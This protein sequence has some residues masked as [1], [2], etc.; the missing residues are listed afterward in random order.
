[1]WSLSSYGCIIIVRKINISRSGIGYSCGV[2]GLRVTRTAKRTKRITLS[3]PG[4]GLS[5]VCE[6]ME[7]MDGNNCLEQPEA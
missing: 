6:S 4:T 2:K 3:I 1:M 7:K 5:Y